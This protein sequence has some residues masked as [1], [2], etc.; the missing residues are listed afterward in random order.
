MNGV[1]AKSII[2]GLL[3]ALGAATTLHAQLEIGTWR[4]EATET[5]PAM[6]LDIQ[7]CCSGGRRLTYHLQINGAET[8]LTVE[9][10]LDGNDAPVL[11]GGQQSGETMAIKRIDAFHATAVVKMNGQVIGTS[12]STLSADGKTLTV[13]NTFAE[14]VPQRPDAATE[15]WVKQ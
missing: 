10:Q 5:G 14:G 1:S 9:T 3:A 2:A 8:T 11:M 13:H 15:V 12:T 6:S 4:R 7:A